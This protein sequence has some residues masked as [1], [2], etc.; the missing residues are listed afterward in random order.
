MSRGG[1]IIF[2]WA[3]VNPEKVTAIYADNPVCDINSWPKADKPTNPTW[4]KCL[5]AYNL[6][7]EQA[8]EFKGNPIDNLEKL[9]KANI[10]I[11]F[12]LG[13]KDTTVPIKENALT[14]SQRYRDLGATQIKTWINPDAGHHPHMACPFRELL[15]HTLST[16]KTDK[17][18]SN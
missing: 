12:S 11:I 17:K 6:T 13:A 9:A 4:L 15:N 7:N 10:P 18:N 1:L 8:I 14:L 16:T 3:K 2:N 5:K